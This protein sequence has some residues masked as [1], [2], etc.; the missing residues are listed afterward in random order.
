M[1]VRSYSNRRLRCCPLCRPDPSD[2]PVSLCD[3]GKQLDEFRN[4]TET[5][6]PRV[7][8][9]YRQNHSFQTRDFV[10]DK[11]IHFSPRTAPEWEFGRRWNFSTRWWTKVIR[12]PS[13]LKLNI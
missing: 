1:G 2:L 8:D 7:R 12:I 3:T 6:P 10:L 9:F 13:S 11:K 5:A 4:Y